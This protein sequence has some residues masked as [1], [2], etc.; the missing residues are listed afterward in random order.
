MG[1]SEVKGK[2]TGNGASFESEQDFL[3]EDEDEEEEVVPGC[4]GP[5]TNRSSS[6]M[7]RV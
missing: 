6:A 2:A 3:E 7:T 5:P 1:C 4:L